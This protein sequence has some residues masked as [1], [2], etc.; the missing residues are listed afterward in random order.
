MYGILKNIYIWYIY[1]VLPTFSIKI[2]QMQVNIHT[3][4]AWDGFCSF[5]W[6]LF[7]AASISWD[8]SPLFSTIWGIYFFQLPEANLSVRLEI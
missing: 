3:W 4:V 7:S 6:C 8:S 5:C 1:H 2:N